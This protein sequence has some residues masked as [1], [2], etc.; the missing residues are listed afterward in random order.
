MLEYKRY[1]FKNLSYVSFSQ[2]IK[3]LKEYLL[4]P[5]FTSLDEILEDEKLKENLE[6]KYLSDE[7]RIWEKIESQ[8]DIHFKKGTKQRKIAEEIINNLD[9]NGILEISLNKLSR[10]CNADISEV[11]KV[12]IYIR[13]TFY[14]KGL[15]CLSIEEYREITGQDLPNPL[16]QM[17]IKTSYILPDIIIKFDRN[18]QELV[19]D[20]PGKNLW[21][22]IQIEKGYG[23]H[24]K[25]FNRAISTLKKSLIKR[26]ENLEKF[27]DYLIKYQE[28]FFTG[29]TSLPI[30]KKQK[31]VAKI[32]NMSP[33]TICRVIKN[34]YVETPRG[35]FP[36]EF[37]FS[38]SPKRLEI[39]KHIAEI[40]KN[41]KKINDQKIKEL[42]EKNYKIKVSRRLVNKIRNEILENL[43]K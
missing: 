36:L 17:N 25:K 21:T 16:S 3:L 10:K 6:G 43:K 24:F 35:I 12:R 15:A 41:Q 1:N 19:Y 4:T 32:L 2:L 18:Q 22:K 37:F 11:E 28:N 5:S 13:D 9:R 33:S 23:K 39:K 29:K 30:I 38:K 26:S 8:L 42:L 27:A 34:K 20:I 31:E 40:L 14:P 7:T